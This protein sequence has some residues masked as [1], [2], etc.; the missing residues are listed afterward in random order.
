MNANRPYLIIEEDKKTF[1]VLTL[2]KNPKD[3]E[4][5]KSLS[6]EEE[7]KPS[8]GRFGKIKC[9]CLKKD[10]YAILHTKILMSP[11]FVKFYRLEILKRNNNIKH[12]CLS[13][14]Q[15]LKLREALETYR[16]KKNKQL[17]LI[18]LGMEGESKEEDEWIL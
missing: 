8:F 12:Q 5:E 14:E 10:T 13:N 15:Y 2:T 4:E 7:D 17:V 11:N 18:E 6:E 16:S 9:D 1:L 3:K